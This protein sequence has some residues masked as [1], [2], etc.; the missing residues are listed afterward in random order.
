MPEAVWVPLFTTLTL[1]A[2]LLIPAIIIIIVL[3]IYLRR[4]KKEETL[5]RK[6]ERPPTDNR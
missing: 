3:Y 6:M 2:Y 1:F 5:E 4:R